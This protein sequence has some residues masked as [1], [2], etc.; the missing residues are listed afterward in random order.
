MKYNLF[1]YT[2]NV[3]DAFLK[4]LRIGSAFQTAVAICEMDSG[5]YELV[6]VPKDQAPPQ[7][8]DSLYTAPIASQMLKQTYYHLPQIN[9]TSSEKLTAKKTVKKV[10]TITPVKATGHGKTTHCL[11]VFSL[12]I[13]AMSVL[14][15]AAISLGM[16]NLFNDGRNEAPSDTEPISQEIANYSHLTNE[17]EELKLQ[18]KQLASQLDLARQDIT[19]AKSDI[20]SINSRIGHSQNPYQNCRKD[21]TTCPL[22]N[23]STTV[24]YCLTPIQEINISVSYFNC[25]KNKVQ[26]TQRVPRSFHL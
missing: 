26:R 25:M 20:G 12:L 22:P 6:D 9:P 17:I 23:S 2:S 4:T 19:Q 21:K 7:N 1:V 5:G 13:T 24:P 18:L 10:N 15:L 11:I 14:T 3:Q 8:K 16:H